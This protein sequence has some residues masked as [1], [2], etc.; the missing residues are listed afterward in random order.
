M[1]SLRINLRLNIISFFVIIIFGLCSKEEGRVEKP[2]GEIRVVESWRPDVNVLGHN[3]LQSLFEYALDKNELAPSLGI[4]RRWI[5]DTTLEIKLRKGVRFHNGE[6]FDSSAVRF[7]FEYQRK[8]NPSRGIQIYL[9]NLK[10]IKVLDTYTVRL[11]LDHPEALILHKLVQ[12]PI[13]AWAIGAPKYMNQVGWQEFLKRPIG[14]GPYMVEGE[15]KNHEQVSEGEVY[16]KLLAAPN[17]WNRGFPKIGK[18]TFVKYSPKEAL[19]A[20]IEGRVDLVTSLLPK[21]TLKVEKG[22][23]S[24]VTKGRQDVTWTGGFLNLMSTHTLPL[25]DMRVRKALNYAVNK[26]ELLRYAFKGNAVGMIGVLNEKTGVDLSATEPYEWNILKARELLQEAGYGNG[27]KI[28]LLYLEKDY[29]LAT[30]LKRFYSLLNIEVDLTSVTWQQVLQ[31]IVYPNTRKGYSWK[32]QD[33]WLI[34]FSHPGVYPELMHTLFEGVF[35]FTGP[36]K[37]CP[38]WLI[39]PLDM[40]YNELLRTK[41]RDKRFQIYKKANEYIADQALWV[42]T[43]A[44]LSLYGVNKEV[45]FVPQVSQYLYLD[46]SSV[47]DGHWS[48][49]GK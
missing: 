23:H 28:K 44:P 46:Y 27:F 43:M 42:F 39:E 36:L 7:N 34:L 12:G 31:H 16:A 11:F 21:D 9:K 24:K 38:D 20:L 37:H 35:H 15:V 32:E 48:L 10:E 6:P 22:G 8:H 45:N 3:V 33:W 19:Q 4:S 29:L 5:D 25:R 40:M 13:A 47:T 30:F 1:Q 14:T 18:I 2:R 26:K 41:D 17:Y 49:K